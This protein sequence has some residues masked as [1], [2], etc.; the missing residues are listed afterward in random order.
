LCCSVCNALLV[1]N[2]DP[3]V[4]LTVLKKTQE[5]RSLSTFVKTRFGPFTLDSETRQLLRDDDEIHLPRKV[6]DLLSTLLAHRPKVLN[7]DELHAAIWPDSHVDAAGLNVLVGDLRR[8]LGDDAK[9]PQFIRT[10]HGIGYAFCG[11]AVHVD[12]HMGQSPSIPA[13]TPC[14]LV[15]GDRTFRLSAGENVIGR[16]PRCSIWLDAARVSR[17]HASIVV[18]VAQG[19]AY[20]RDLEST[21]G[22]FLGRSRVVQPVALSDGDDV[23][24]GSVVLKFRRWVPE[25]AV[26]TRRIR[27]KGTAQR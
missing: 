23:K 21:N 3:P 17:R 10:V 20:I 15:W 25:R 4:G 7:K 26:E 9:R 13:A 18:D 12:V 5:F 22:T 19:T 27:R 14:W 8:A 24:I 16:D 6:F 11:D 1:V 2:Y